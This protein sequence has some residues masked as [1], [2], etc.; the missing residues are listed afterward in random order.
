M[1]EKKICVVTGTRADYGL[2]YWVLKAIQRESSLALQIVATGMHLSTAFGLTYRD[3]EADGFAIDKKVE[4]LLASDSDVGVTKSVGL[5]TI[6]FADAFHALAPDIVVLLGDR[7]E[8]LAAATAALIARIPVAH[9]HGGE[10]TEGAIDES[11]R[12]AVTKMAHLH[13]VATDAFRA[14]VVQLGEDPARVITVGAPGIDYIRHVKLLGRR[15]LER[16]L[17]FELGA[18]NFLVTYHPATL[19]DEAPED[20]IRE[21][22]SAVEQFPEAKVIF[23]MPNADPGGNEISRRIEA[24]VEDFP[25]RAMV[26]KSLGQVRYLSTIAQVDAVIGNSSSGIIEVPVLRK[27]TVNVG[28][29][30]RGRPRAD[31][32]VDCAPRA[33]EIAEAI[34]RVCS[35]SFKATLDKTVS[36]YGEGGAAERIL[37]VLTSVNLDRLLTKKFHD[38]PTVGEASESV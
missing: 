4:M 30:Q 13:L 25:G 33:D 16:S 5:G 1:V 10:T 11:I 31:S 37:E 9:I 35:P 17:G 38:M 24:F 2:L 23:T 8:I 21:L 34:R 7:F 3:I 22:L 14:R 36:P 15:E 18:R 32:V 29:R 20:A 19:G 6:G 27:P 12:H 26:A 28:S